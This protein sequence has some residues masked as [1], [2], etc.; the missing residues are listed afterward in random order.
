LENNHHTINTQLKRTVKDSLIYLPA[1]LVPAIIGILLIRILTTLFSPEEYGYYQITLSTFGL[2]KVFGMVWLSTSVTRFYLNYKKQK[3]ENIFFSTLFICTVICALLVALLSFLINLIVF[4]K[5]LDPALFSLI[6]LA[7]V[8]SIFTAFFEIFVVVYRA[9]LEPKKYTSYWLLFVVGKPLLGIL[10]ILVFGLKVNGIFWAF[11]IIPTILDII[12]FIKLDIQKYLKIS[13]ISLS[14]F[15]QFFKYGIPISFSFL[16]F[17][18]LS[19]SDRYFIEFFRDSAEVGLYS[20]GYVISEKTL[21]FIYMVLMLAAYPII[22]DNW[23][24]HGD[25]HTQTL[26][27][28]LSRYYLFL[29]VPILITLV[30]IPKT[31]LLIFS[32][33][34]FVDGAVVLPLI[35]SG[36][37][38][39]GLTQYV[40]KGFELHKKSYKIALLSCIAGLTNIGI[41]IILIPKF[42]YLGAGISAAFSYLVY[43]LIAIFLAR[44]ELPWLPPYKSIF[45]S[46][47]AG[48]IF[49][50]F[51]YY[52]SR[53]T[54]N[55]FIIAFLFIPLGVVLFF[56]ILILLKEI[57]RAEIE[58]ARD[59]LTDL[60]SLKK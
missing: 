12:I 25:E 35:A 5:T 33:E 48:S 22:I 21:N 52:S 28:E 8:A 2:I 14:L 24:K 11:I 13:N 19:L 36:I 26:I 6:N 39:Y 53:I 23:E 4:K 49:S 17:W 16:A 56:L 1:K 42:G 50:L 57:N 20:V 46:L 34:K 7:I 59:F 32:S 38:L 29:C 9:G 58:K 47:I 44:K 55:L 54:P 30:T 41:N 10:L 37:F 18:I 45:N 43:F 31:I 27:T 60:T 51:L 15:K 40:Q 3:K